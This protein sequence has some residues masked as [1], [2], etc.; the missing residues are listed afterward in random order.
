M[1]GAARRNPD[2]LVNVILDD[3]LEENRMQWAERFALM[4]MWCQAA[5]D[6]KRRRMA[7]GLIT[8]A[9]ALVDDTRLAEIPAMK[10]IAA[11]TMSA[12]TAN[13]W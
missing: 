1:K 5:P 2:K 12:E 8:T 6:P 10:M 7:R 13:P 4:G 3:V 11:R 9:M